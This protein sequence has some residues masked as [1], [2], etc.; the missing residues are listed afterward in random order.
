MDSANS[1]VLALK[2]TIT[3]LENKLH[4]IGQTEQMIFLNSQRNNR[5]YYSKEGLGFQNPCKFNKAYGKRPSLYSYEVQQIVDKYPEFGIRDLLV[6][7]N[8]E[9]ESELMK[10][11]DAKFTTMNFC[12]DY[13]N[14]TYFSNPKHELNTEVFLTHSPEESYSKIEPK[15][16]VPTLLLEEQ[17]VQLKDKIVKLEDKV[18]K[19]QSENESLTTQITHLK[20]VSKD[21]DIGGSEKNQTHH[22]QKHL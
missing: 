16:C 11:H 4:K 7:N 10:S 1:T 6:T 15:P 17:I 21:T 19:L 12:Y 18:Q 14:T 8:A 9:H 22:L 13:M 2:E 3:Y 20:N 5:D